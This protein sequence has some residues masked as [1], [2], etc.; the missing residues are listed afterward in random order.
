MNMEPV[1]TD[2]ETSDVLRPYTEGET[3]PEHDAWIKAKINATLAK[4]AAGEMNYHSL[5][6]VM[7]EFG[8]NAR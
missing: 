8:F 6:D 7:R 5:D 1:I 2:E 3:P 4:K